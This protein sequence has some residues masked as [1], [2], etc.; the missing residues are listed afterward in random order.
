MSYDQ[1]QTK[2]IFL[3]KKYTTTT[4]QQMERNA[5][6]LI[7][8][9]QFNSKAA[10][11]LFNQAVGSWPHQMLRYLAD[12]NGVSAK[13]PASPADTGQLLADTAVYWNL[14]GHIHLQ[15]F[16]QGPHPILF[17]PMYPTLWGS[18]HKET[19]AGLR[20]EAVMHG[21]YSSAVPLMMWLKENGENLYPAPT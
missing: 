5:C 2:R 8:N 9:N 16:F 19:E 1:P 3:G 4:R 7:V 12:I 18:H 10:S 17:H 15:L 13:G 6:E 14:L 20:R 11:P 21:F